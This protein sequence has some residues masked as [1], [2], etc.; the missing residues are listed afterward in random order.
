M[1]PKESFDIE[2]ENVTL[3]TE[4]RIILELQ[5]LREE[6]NDK[7]KGVIRLEDLEKI[8]ESH[9]LKCP[10][11]EK[12][13]KCEAFADMWHQTRRTHESDK[14]KAFDTKTNFAKNIWWWLV[15]GSFIFS[16]MVFAAKN[17]SSMQYYSKNNEIR[18]TSL[19]EVDELSTL[20]KRMLEMTNLIEDS[21]YNKRK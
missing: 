8:L 10:Q 11:S 5:K 3:K 4:N 7:F 17:I 19:K 15:A 9:S 13:V 16:M 1:N 21:I 20:K 12:F 18:N 6:M 2:M 14:I